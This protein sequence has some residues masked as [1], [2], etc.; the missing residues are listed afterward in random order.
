M[1]IQYS[2]VE[3]DR[4]ELLQPNRNDF[5]MADYETTQNKFKV[6]ICIFHFTHNDALTPCYLPS[7]QLPIRTLIICDSKV[8]S[9]AKNPLT[10]RLLSRKRQLKD[11]RTESSEGPE[12]LDLIAHA[13]IGATPEYASLE[14]SM[15][16]TV[17]IL[18]LPPES[19]R[20]T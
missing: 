8:H 7:S 3:C 2:Q 16:T 15:P 12:S 10:S 1:P 11:I 13:E 18:V 14:S 9:H 19:V 17:P 4:K 20:T 5:V 6:Q